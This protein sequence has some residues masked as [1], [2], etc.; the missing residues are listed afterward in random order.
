M[1]KT[2]KPAREIEKETQTLKL[3]GLKKKNKENLRTPW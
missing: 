1:Y 3:D 2:S